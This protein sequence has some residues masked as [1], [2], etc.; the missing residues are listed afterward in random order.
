MG[1][2]ALSWS[3]RGRL[4]QQGRAG[5]QVENDDPEGQPGAVDWDGDRY[6]G[7]DIGVAVEASVALS[8]AEKAAGGAPTESEICNSHPSQKARR[9]GHPSV[10]N[11]SRMS[12]PPLERQ[13][14]FDS[15]ELRRV[16]SLSG[17]VS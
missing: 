8:G 11:G 3:D 7:S 15:V 17:L 1:L 2:A 4:P 16:V 14:N 10:D 5:L 6:R 9:M 13:I 12:H